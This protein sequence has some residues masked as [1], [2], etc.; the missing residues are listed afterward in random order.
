MTRRT[1]Y[2]L[3][4]CGYFMGWTVVLI[5]LTAIFNLSLAALMFVAV[6]ALM[7]PTLALLRLEQPK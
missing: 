1:L 6:I 2:S 5:F 7:P 4:F 3:F